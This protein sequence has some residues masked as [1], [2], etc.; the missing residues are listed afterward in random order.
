MVEERKRRKVTIALAASLLLVVGLGSAAWVHNERQTALHERERVERRLAA[1]KIV[2]DD[3]HAADNRIASVSSVD[4]GDA[5][6]TE[7]E[8]SLSTK[9]IELDKAL[10]RATQAVESAGH[11]EVGDQLRTATH[12]KFAQVE[13]LRSEC[14]SEL[15]RVTSF[16]QLRDDLE[17]IRLS[18]AGQENKTSVLGKNFFA[19]EKANVQYEEA[20]RKAGL[21]LFQGEADDTQSMIQQS[22]IREE[23]I[24]SLDQWARAIS[25]LSPNQRQRVEVNFQPAQSIGYRF[26]D[27]GSCRPKRLEEARPLLVV[28]P[29]PSCTGS[30]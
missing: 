18:L 16:R 22:P 3:L 12:D 19:N 10:I 27:R 7:Q 14:K 29:C 21:D 13:Q 15:D 5:D 2:R 8:S 24:A 25:N 4:I 28:V 11:E 1:E 17:N 9:L 23:L 6:L 30:S 26:H 20:F